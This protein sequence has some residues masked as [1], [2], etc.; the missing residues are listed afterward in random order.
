MLYEVLVRTA[1]TTAMIFLIIGTAAT[2][3]HVLTLKQVPQYLAGD[4]GLLLNFRAR[5]FLRRL[6]FS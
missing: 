2:F 1:K 5:H 3:A 6:S 4:I